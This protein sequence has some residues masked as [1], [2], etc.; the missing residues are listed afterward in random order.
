VTG[1]IMVARGDLG[2]EMAFPAVPV[3]QK[4]ITRKCEAAA[5]PCIIATEMLE[6]MIHSRTPT[7]AEVSDVANAVFDHCAEDLGDRVVHSQR[8]HRAADRQEQAALSDPRA[9]RGA[10]RRSTVSALLRRGSEADRPS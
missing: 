5:K 7:R 9:L 1:A 8:N 3:A 6:S 4:S 10:T 2:V